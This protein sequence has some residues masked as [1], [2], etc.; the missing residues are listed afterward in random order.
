MQ[1]S[2]SGKQLIKDFQQGK[3]VTIQSS[4]TS[5]YM[6]DKSQENEN[7]TSTSP[8]NSLNQYMML[9]NTPMDSVS[10]KKQYANKF[11]VLLQ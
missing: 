6:G 11:N 4:N 7:T 9:S 5:S 1:S 8:N 10:D 2:E 3:N